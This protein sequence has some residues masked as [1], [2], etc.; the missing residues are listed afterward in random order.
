MTVRR[1]AVLPPAV[2]VQTRMWDALSTS[3]AIAVPWC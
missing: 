3:M 1:M 2:P